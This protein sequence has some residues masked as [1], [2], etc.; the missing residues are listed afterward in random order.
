M[1]STI[2]VDKIEGGTGSTITVPTGQ[3]LTIVDGVPVASGGT[4]FLLSLQEM[5]S[6]RLVQ[7]H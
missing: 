4:G 2:K 6:M 3:T 7:L 1:A 5:F